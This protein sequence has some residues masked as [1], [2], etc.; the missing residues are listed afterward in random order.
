MPSLK[1]RLKGNTPLRRRERTLDIRKLIKN[2]SQKTFAEEFALFKEELQPEIEA[3]FDNIVED[4]LKEKLKGDIGIQ[5][6]QGVKGEK[7]DVGESIKGDKGDKGDS[8]KGE[9]G[10]DAVGEKGEQGD[11]GDGGSPDTPNQIIEKINK[12]R[13]KIPISKISGLDEMFTSLKRTI[14]RISVKKGGGGG[15]MGNPVHETFDISAGTT[16]VTLASNIAANG[17][18]I[19]TASYEGQNLELT[20]HYTISGKTLTFHSDV[21]AQF[22]NSTIFYISYI[23][24]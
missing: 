15:G 23:R 4:R 22:V 1:D 6:D 12:T 13:T 2:T 20:N 5:G 9:R 7:G 3:W 14:S 19:F 21:Q 18:A 24:T 17:T 11:K 8:I 10:D 16:S